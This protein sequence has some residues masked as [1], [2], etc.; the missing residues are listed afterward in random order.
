[1]S[2]LVKAFFDQ[3]LR[4]SGEEG[5]VLARYTIG[6]DLGFVR[7][8]WWG[9]KRAVV[10]E[11][12]GQN[13]GLT[14]PKNKLKDDSDYHRR[15]FREMRVTPRERGD[16]VIPLF[17][18]YSVIRDY[19]HDKEET[20]ALLG[21]RPELRVIIDPIFVLIDNKDPIFYDLLSE[22]VGIVETR[23]E[24]PLI[25]RVSIY[26]EKLQS[27]PTYAKYQYYIDLLKLVTDVTRHSKQS[28]FKFAYTNPPEVERM[29]NDKIL[30]Q[31]IIPAE[32][33]ILTYNESDEK[34]KHGLWAVKDKDAA[35]GEGFQ[36]MHHR[37]VV[38]EA[39]KNQRFKQY[40]LIQELLK[41]VGA[42]NAPTF[43]KRNHSAMRLLADVSIRIDKHGKPFAVIESAF[44]THNVYPKTSD[45]RSL[46]EKVKRPLPSW[47]RF[48]PKD[49]AR[50]VESSQEELQMGE[51]VVKKIAL[52]LFN[53]VTQPNASE[54]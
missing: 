38:T 47:T 20:L 10:F 2:N 39:G 15:M 40:Y 3:K 12:N 42:D 16:A 37:D 49:G 32:N 43:E 28:V 24:V 30:Q 1:R 36:K 50:P 41:T 13:A 52:N 46:V 48:E 21:A 31:E 45:A 7:D 22:L 33:M 29:L 54:S 4:E 11:V 5:E 6:A 27:N 9:K 51:D 35:R 34:P 26:I 8:H 53:K 17:N 18:F 44:S 23:N 19:L 14:I 25:K